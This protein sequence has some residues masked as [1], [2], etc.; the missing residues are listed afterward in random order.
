MWDTAVNQLPIPSNEA[1]ASSG[2]PARGMKGEP[3]RPPAGCLCGGISGPVRGYRHILRDAPV[4]P[5]G[6]VGGGVVFFFPCF[7]PLAAFRGAFSVF[8]R[9]LPVV[10][11]VTRQ[12]DNR[13]V[14][15]AVMA[16]SLSLLISKQVL[17]TAAKLLLNIGK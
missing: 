12:P 1:A 3:V 15:M 5:S 2:L 7:F 14:A 13:A 10:L 9:G 4:R 6:F 8:G 16:S 17:I 11:S